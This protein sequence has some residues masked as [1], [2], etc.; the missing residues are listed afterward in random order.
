MAVEVIDAQAIPQSWFARRSRI[1]DCK[2][3]REAAT[4]LGNRFAIPT[5]PQPRRLPIY[6]VRQKQPCYG[7]NDLGWAKLS[8]R[9]G[10]S[11]LA[12]R[13]ELTLSTSGCFPPERKPP[14]LNQEP[15]PLWRLS[16]PDPHRIL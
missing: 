14:P 7:I 5:F 2:E 9:T 8:R 10:P 15:I 4:A 6:K 16:N 3:Y 1:L 13:N 11:G 12:K